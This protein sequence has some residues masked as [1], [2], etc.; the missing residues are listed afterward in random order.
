ML[1][2]LA[3]HT[4]VQALPQVPSVSKTMSFGAK[5]ARI[6]LARD[7]TPVILK[8]GLGSLKCIDW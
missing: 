7:P 3:S 8:N 4:N 5:T 1:K 2:Q 6:G